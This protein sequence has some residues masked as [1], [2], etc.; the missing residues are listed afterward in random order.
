MGLLLIESMN[1]FVL[2]LIVNDDR[3]TDAIILL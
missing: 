2:R 3:L 1:F